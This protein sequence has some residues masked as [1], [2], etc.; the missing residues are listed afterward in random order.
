MINDGV[1]IL[2]HLDR[3]RHNARAL[4]A[5]CNDIM[6]VIK[7]DAYGHGLEETAAI[8]ESDGIGWF[9]IGAVDE[10]V[11]LRKAGITSN[12]VALLGLLQPEDAML[13]IENGII[14]LVHSFAVLKQIAD[15][16]RPAD[17]AIK[18][19]TGMN[20]LGF[21]LKDIPKL[22]EALQSF[23][24]LRPRIAITHLACADEERKDTITVEQINAFSSCVSS[25]RTHFP[26]MKASCLNSPGLLSWQE[27]C[28]KFPKIKSQA[29]LALEMARPGIVL[30]GENPLAGTVREDLGKDVLPVME[31]QTSVLDIHTLQQGDS[32]GYGH[33][34][35]APSPR[36]VA[37]IAAGYAEGFPRVLSNK[38]YVCLKGG[39]APIIGRV[40]MQMSLIDITNQPDIAP[41]DTVWI[42]GGPDNPVV[43]PITARE[44]AGWAGTISYEILCSLGRNRRVFLP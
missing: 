17:I 20:R 5:R 11:R 37:V 18:C 32:I 16:G 22:S 12:I 13:A 38:G 1:K 41:G 26:E 27:Y 19:N 24:L 15:C 14:P 42:L 30:Y 9:A 44:M 6:P 23:P 39:R 35:T 21:T 25:L 36:R 34:Y 3:L 31:A 40:C 7:A 28:G 29:S 33:T 4:K 43:Q 10:G 8:F 2:I